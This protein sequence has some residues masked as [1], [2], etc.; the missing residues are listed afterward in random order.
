M[1]KA[2]EDLQ[3][4]KHLLKASRALSSVAVF[5]CQQAAEKTLKAFL[6]WHD[7]PF[8]KTHDL[9]EIGESCI[10]LDATL[11]EVVDRAV[12]LTE[13]AWK[14]SYP[15]EPEHPSRREVEF[16]LTLASEVN[17]DVVARLPK[18]VRS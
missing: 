10:K 18:R 17:L 15:G 1:R 5:H 13:Y 2:K 3:A 7:V 14:F 8:R 4:A 11:K 12:P 6:A 16:A 9:E